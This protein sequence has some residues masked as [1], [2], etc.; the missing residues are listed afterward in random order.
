MSEEN[1]TKKTKVKH[2][3]YE[4][5]FV[6]GM[7]IIVGFI[8]WALMS[9]RAQQLYAFVKK[10]KLAQEFEDW[11]AAHEKNWREYQGMN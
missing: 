6:L 9:Y 7:L 10:K 8:G 4:T 2:M 5:E 3:V 1:E 11:K